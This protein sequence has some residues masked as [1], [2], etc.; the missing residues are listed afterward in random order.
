MASRDPAGSQKPAKVVYPPVGYAGEYLAS[1][2]CLLSKASPVPQTK[3][4]AL[5]TG[6]QA[7]YTDVL[8]EAQSQRAPIRTVVGRHSPPACTVQSSPVLDQ[9]PV[10]SLAL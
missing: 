10:M 4:A 9:H 5:F 8:P 6:R 7:E 3:P 1:C 2:T